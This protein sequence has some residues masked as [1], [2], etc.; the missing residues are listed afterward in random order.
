[1]A[2]DAERLVEDLARRLEAAADDRT[3]EWW[4][5]YLKGAVPFRG[6]PMAGIRTAVR[7][8]WTDERVQALPRDRQIGLALRLFAE[9]YCEDKLAGVLALA[10]HLLDDLGLGDVPRLAAP[11]EDG[12]IADWN[13]CDWY[14]VKVLG[15]LVERAPD[16]RAAAEAIAGWRAATGLWQRRAAAVAFVNLAPRGDALFPGFVERVRS[17]C[18][19]NVRDPARFSQ[20]GVGWVLRQLS[21][22]DPDAVAAFVRGHRADMS[23]E[24]LRSATAKLRSGVNVR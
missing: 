20:T 22:A 17:V 13:T 11:F 9:P 21:R 15:P 8:L 7:E 6:V 1:M 3:R 5:R 16:R 10:E 14:C 23:R 18:A 4:E 2:S 19:A 12:H 24:A